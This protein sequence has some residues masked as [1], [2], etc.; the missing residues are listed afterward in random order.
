[1]IKICDHKSAGMVVRAERKVLMID[2][3]NY[4]KKCKALPAGHCDKETFLAAAIKELREEAGFDM[5]EH[6]SGNLRKLWGGTIAN[7]CKREGGSF[8]DWEIFGR[9][10]PTAPTVKAGDD[11]RRAF[12]ATEEEWKHYAVRT[13]W[14]YSKLGLNWIEVGTLT[15][16]IFGQ[17]GIGPVTDE[18]K[19]L[20]AEWRR[21]PGM[22]PACYF[23]LRKIGFFSWTF[24]DAPVKAA[25]IST[26]D[27]PDVC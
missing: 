8:H 4:P 21:D 22:E 14:F 27:A 9:D 24:Q 12:W 7:P 11:A 19:A 6:P 16:K 2:R 5:L 20:H 26:V 1:M 23:M 15:L 13:E 17:P 10:F 3:G 18:E 25:P